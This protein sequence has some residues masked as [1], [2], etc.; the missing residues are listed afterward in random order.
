MSEGLDTT[1]KSKKAMRRML[2]L[3]SS[4]PAL[5]YR[6]LNQ[7]RSVGIED[8]DDRDDTRGL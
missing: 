5:D 6:K 7:R 8:L 1:S 3:D 4:V 2:G